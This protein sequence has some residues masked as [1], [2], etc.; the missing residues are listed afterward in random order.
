MAPSPGEPDRGGL[1]SG[2]QAHRAPCTCAHRDAPL[3]LRKQPRAGS[4]CGWGH[5][6]GSRRS[7]PRLRGLCLRLRQIPM[8]AAALKFLIGMFAPEPAPRGGPHPQGRREVSCWLCLGGEILQ[9]L[10]RCSKNT[11][12]P[13]NMINVFSNDIN[14]PMCVWCA[15][16]QR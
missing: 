6:A 1:H 8:R 7:A 4:E 13:P 2:A 9:I 5:E 16:K 12:Q 14:I 11:E 3:P 10:D 15:E